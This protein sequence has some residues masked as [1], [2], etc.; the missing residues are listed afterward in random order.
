ML[1]SVAAV[2]LVVSATAFADHATHRL[3]A[4]AG[5]VAARATTPGLSRR[6]TRA[7][8]AAS[9]ALSKETYY[10]SADVAATARAAR[11][12]ERAFPGDVEFGADLDAAIAAFRAD[13]AADRSG[14]ED[15]LPSI[16][17]PKSQSAALRRLDRI[18]VDDAGRPLRSHAAK[19][20]RIARRAAVLDSAY[21]LAGV[22]PSFVVGVA[23]T[24]DVGAHTVKY[25]PYVSD[26]V[27][28][29]TDAGRLD[30]GGIE[31]ERFDRRTGIAYGHSML[32]GLVIDG[33]G[34]TSAPT[35]A[36]GTNYAGPENQYGDRV[37]WRIDSPAT[38][39]V[40]RFDPGARVVE[41]TFSFSA[42]IPSATPLYG[43]MPVEV[44]V[45]NG[46]FRARLP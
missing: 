36:S 15:L 44:E 3:D 24:F 10:E 28:A 34:T 21:R 33:L 2:S 43:W 5:H 16:V 25:A 9:R 42:G 39:T 38:L 22:G 11:P 37:A 20:S 6:Q 46:R 1:R 41:G 8:A 7:L 23:P 45:S 13:L 19:L 4:L 40:T 31:Y 32:I 30:V 12:L 14:L 29:W 27:E 17:D 35:L 18:P 26:S